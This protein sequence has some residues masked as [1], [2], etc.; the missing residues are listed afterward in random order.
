MPPVGGTSRTSIRATVDLPDPDSPTMPRVLAAPQV[1]I[2]VLGG[3]DDAPFLEQAPRHI[4]FRQ[5]PRAQHDRLALLRRADG[6]VHAR[7]RLD[8]HFRIGVLRTPQHILGRPLFD[9]AALPHDDDAMGDVRDDAEIMRDE[10]DAGAAPRP[11]LGDQL[12]DLRLR[13]DVEGGRRLVRD[14]QR[15]IEDERAGDH[16]ALALPA[17]HLVRKGAH[18]AVGIGQMHG[19]DRLA[20][21]REPLGRTH[22]RVNG[23]HF[24]DLVADRA[25]GI[26]RGH[27][28]LEDHRH[29]RAAQVTVAGLGRSDE[30]LAREPDGAGDGLHLGREQAHDREGTD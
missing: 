30:F 26:E 20:D 1:D 25:H 19:C 16:R 2:D 10:Q 9:D 6:R 3:L 18:D 29:A 22:P 28:L 12:E 8:Q 15:R 17:R 24:L 5:P 7:H 11:Q 13:G 23:E 14:Q 27:R 4:G 21:A